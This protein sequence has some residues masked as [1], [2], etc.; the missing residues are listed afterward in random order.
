M[1]QEAGPQASLGMPRIARCAQPSAA[2]DTSRRPGLLGLQL[3]VAGET[4]TIAKTRAFS[5]GA[6]AYLSKGSALRETRQTGVRWGNIG[7]PRRILTGR[8]GAEPDAP[9]RIR[10]F[11]AE[12][13]VHLDDL[14]RA[15]LRLTGKAPEAEDLVQETCLRAFRALD[16]LRHPGAAR[17]WVF[18]ILRSVFLR[19]VE[20]RARRPEPVNL[21]D[22]E[23]SC[24]RPGEA[25]RDLYEHYS[26]RPDR[27]RHEVREAV[28]R[29][30]LA[31]REA[32]IL[33]HVGGFSYREMARI[34]AVPLGTVMSRLFRA[35][36]MLRAFLREGVREVIR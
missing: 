16:Q 9:E 8:V 14:Y 10:R 29:L 17:A 7:A 15:A 1:S 23:A 26:L 35:R 19:E 20:R 24:L 28:L 5:R 25:L 34:L 32:L 2:G 12:V 4:A 21:E 36:R 33:A 30:P 11:E 27:L 31:Y 13:L 6:A 18:A 3:A 22:L